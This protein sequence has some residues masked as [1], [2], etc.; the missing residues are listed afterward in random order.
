I[1]KA[2]HTVPNSSDDD[3]SYNGKEG[4]RERFDLTEAEG[5]GRCFFLFFC[6]GGSGPQN[7]R[8]FSPCLFFD[9]VLVS[10]T[11]VPLQPF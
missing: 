5:G 1:E 10:F 3:D 4:K 2:V 11:L 8:R 7:Q 6:G 9:A